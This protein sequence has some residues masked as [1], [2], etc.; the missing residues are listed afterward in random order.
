MVNLEKKEIEV[1]YKLHECKSNHQLY[2]KLIEQW[3]SD[4][5]Y[6][7]AITDLRDRDFVR[8][9]INYDKVL[10]I[11]LAPRGEAWLLDHPANT[12]T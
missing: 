3:N 11:K 10:D 2:E 9:Y 5:R 4:M 6:F 12:P 1:L 7:V 8:A